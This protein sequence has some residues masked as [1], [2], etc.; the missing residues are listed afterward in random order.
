MKDEFHKTG[1]LNALRF[2]VLDACDIQKM[3]LII[4]DEIAFHLSGRHTT[5]WLSNI[6]HRQIEI[7]EDVYLHARKGKNSGQSNGNHSDDN[8]N[9]T[10][11]CP[12]RERHLF[13]LRRGFRHH[14][15]EWLYI[16][17]SNR[18]GE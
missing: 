8:C 7:R 14:V 16:S 12:I 11:H 5:I 3:I 6:N 10:L 18:C 9:W 13:A 4:I 15:Q 1:S 2:D 17:F